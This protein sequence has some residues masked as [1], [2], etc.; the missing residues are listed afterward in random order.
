MKI[1]DAVT[2][3]IRV[4]LPVPV[5]G[6]SCEV[7]WAAPLAYVA[8][9]FAW[10]DM[11]EAEQTS[12]TTTAGRYIERALSPADAPMPAGTYTLAT[13]ELRAVS[14]GLG[15][16]EL[17]NMQAGVYNGDQIEQLGTAGKGAMLEIVLDSGA[18]VVLF[19][20]VI[21]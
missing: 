4:T 5:H 8:E 10:G 20:V 21:I 7:R 13:L 9:S 11:P 17:I 18:P 15:S 19:E 6:L 12:N 1:G 16:V 2:I 14:A 3:E